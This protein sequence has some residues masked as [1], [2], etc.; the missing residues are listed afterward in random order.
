MTFQLCLAIDENPV[1]KGRPRF[2][3]IGQAIA[4]YTPKK[5]KTFE[6]LVK[7]RVKQAMGASEPL[8]SPVSVFLGFRLS[9]P[10]S[11]PK[12][13]T[14]A[15]LEGL[16]RHCKKPDLDNLAKS[17]LDGLNGVVF[18]DDSQVVQLHC[19]KDYSAEPGVDILVR[20]ELL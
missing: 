6:D 9:V 13:R 10:K 4:S 5:T 7:S 14:K 20:E 15:C 1:P 3:R 16:E 19:R 8:Q 2:R 12:S 11:Y 18:V 17:V